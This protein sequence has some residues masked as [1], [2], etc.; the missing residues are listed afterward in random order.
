MLRGDGHFSNP[1]LMQLALDTPNTD[2]IFGLP[3]NRILSP[4]AQPFLEATR[5]A[6][7]TRCAL[8]QG[9][10]Q[11]EPGTTRTYHDLAYQAK[12]WPKAFRVVL[13]AEV[14]TLGD[15]PR[16]V[17]T[18]LEQPSA[19]SLY[20]DLYCARGQDENWI[21]MMKNDLSSDRTSDHR[22]LANHLRLYFSCAA[23]VLH[24]TLRTDVLVHTELAQA[25]PYTV[26]LKLFKIAVRVI[27]YK[28]RIK[29]QL[30]S[31]C[32]VQELLYRVTEILFRVR[33]PVWDTS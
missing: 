6:H 10:N 15:N 13:K 18:S 2:F 25:Q 22:F 32:P 20:R 29:L 4:L 21:K 16:F 11:T 23:Y 19:E 31:S 12:T 3:G 5:L 28:D 8:A 33:E 17:V 24:Q 14:L 9:Q 27:Q 30:P 1:E 7:Q 26:I